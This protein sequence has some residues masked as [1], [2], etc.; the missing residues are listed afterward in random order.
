ME[1][2]GFISATWEQTGSGR[3]ARTYQITGSGK[4]QLE[5]VEARWTSVAEAVHRVL[6]MA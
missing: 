3:R 5:M 6:R 1:E 2:A 4:E